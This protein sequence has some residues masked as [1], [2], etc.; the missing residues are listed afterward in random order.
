MAIPSVSRLP[1]RMAACCTSALRRTFRPQ[2]TALLIVPAQTRPRE[3]R[4]VLG[5]LVRVRRTRVG[6]GLGANARPW[7]AVAIHENTGP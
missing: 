2:G 1:P 3:P 6:H 4:Y 7:E 5:T